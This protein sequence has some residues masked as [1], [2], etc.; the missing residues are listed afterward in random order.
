MVA[1]RAGQT[2]QCA[3]RLVGGVNNSELVFV[4]VHHLPMAEI[5]V[6]GLKRKTKRVMTSP[7]QVKKRLAFPDFVASVK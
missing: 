3:T 6:L 1:G 7:V 4:T 5:L 2:G